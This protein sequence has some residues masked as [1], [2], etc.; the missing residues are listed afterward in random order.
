[1]ERVR[2]LRRSGRRRLSVIYKRPDFQAPIVKDSKMR[3]VPDVSYNAA[4]DGGV[5]VF[6]GVPLGP[7]AAFRF[8]GTSAGSPQ[9]AGLAAITDQLAG[10]R[11]G[12]I[13]KTLYKLGK[14]DQGTYFHDIADGSNNGAFT[15][16]VRLRRGRDGLGIADRS[17]A[18]PGDRE[19]RER[20][21]RFRQD[22][23]EGRLRAAFAFQ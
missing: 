6:W 11:V 20:L 9:W 10:G 13:N 17:G 3:V 14:K 23:G 1:M 8:G 19:A 7:G 12:N 2:D 15:R 4:V 16:D 5:I 22:V 21:G 18:R